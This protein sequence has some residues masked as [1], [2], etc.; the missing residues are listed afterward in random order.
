[1]E[2]PK[3]YIAPL[4]VRDT[5]FTYCELHAVLVS[6]VADRINDVRLPPLTARVRLASLTPRE[7]AIHVVLPLSSTRRSR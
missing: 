7:D 6:D 3:S 1:M 2:R 4:K 5:V